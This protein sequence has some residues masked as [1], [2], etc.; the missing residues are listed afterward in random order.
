MHKRGIY[1]SMLGVP[2]IQASADAKSYVLGKV[3]RLCEITS[4]NIKYLQTNE[5]MKKR[6]YVVRYEDIAVK[7]FEYA[8]EILDFAGLDYTTE[9]NNWIV[10]NTRGLTGTLLNY[11]DIYKK[12]YQI[13]IHQI[14][15]QFEASQR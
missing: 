2:Q 9:V 12:K 7:P 11:I 1:N 6:T 14:T 8:K 4:E 3:K 5:E 13:E 10:E 15:V